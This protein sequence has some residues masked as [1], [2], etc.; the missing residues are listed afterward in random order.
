M[1]E[2]RFRQVHMDFHTSES[3]RDI[4]AKFRPDRFAD[5][6]QKACVDS[7]TCF[8]RCHHGWLYYKSREFPERIHP[9][10]ANKNLL[11]EQIEACH[12]RGIRVPIYTTVQWDHYTAGRHPEWLA[13]TADG[14][15]SGTAPFE[16]GFYRTLCVNSPYRDF[17][18]AHT[19]EVL[20][21]LPVDGLFFDIVG[22]RECACGHC[23]A[24]MTDRG[25]D[26]AFED[27]RMQFARQT[28]DEFKLDMSRFVRRLKR[29]ATIFYNAGHVDP[30]IHGS[31]KAYSHL[32]LESLPTGGWGYMHFP[33]TARYARTLGVDFLGMT[34]KFHTSW[35]DFHSFKNQAA[36]EFECFNALALG[37]RCSVGD[38]LL[39]S[40]RICPHT[41]KL[42]GSVY[43]Q[44]KAKEP[45]CRDARPVAEI[46]LLTPEEFRVSSTH[47]DGPP[48]GVQGAVRILQETGHQFDIIDSGADFRAFRLLILPDEYPVDDKLARRI[49]K[50]LSD[51]GALIA[52]FES[53]LKPDKSDFAV[54]GLGVS[55][56]GPAP[57]NP[58]F[59][60]PGGPIGRGMPRTEH[61][62][63]MRGLQV[64][65]KR[66]A[67]VLAGVRKPYFNRTWEHFCSHRHTPSSGRSAYPGIVQKRGS[68]YFAHPVFS[69]YNDNAPE[70]CK[71]LVVNALDLL[72]PDRLVTHDGPTTVQVALNEQPRKKRHVLH[73]LH[74]IP[75]R[76]AENMDVIKDVIPLHD[77]AVSGKAP[78]TIKKVRCVPE[79]QSLAFEQRDGRVEFVLPRLEGHQMIEMTC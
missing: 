67:K 6:L 21:T 41:Y 50:Y 16:A 32:E 5:T 42:I 45:W 2:L 19:R 22:V 3:I 30:S 60:V 56:V 17:L 73:L 64:R 33:V 46:G 15:I 29:G 69:Q 55:L 35:G 76:R 7:V 31:L 77:L 23:R 57:Y 1:P 47:V 18:K 72:L 61:V 63:Y 44:V 25:M 36:L 27:D 26:P 37:A 58:D 74:Y 75:E 54:K 70:W 11:A 53:G 62:M 66:G 78:R 68:V 10:L 14:K 39:P 71:Q 40:G 38:Q 9:H 43:S 65:A 59:V 24:G 49:E 52:S 34:G 48:T 13:I 12:E 79:R 4:G 8:A 51:G 28:M 20:R